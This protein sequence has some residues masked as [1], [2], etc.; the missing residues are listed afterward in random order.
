MKAKAKTVK[1]D[2]IAVLSG[3]SPYPAKRRYNSSR[4][5]PSFL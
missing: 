1:A 3:F 2:E 4:I 5:S